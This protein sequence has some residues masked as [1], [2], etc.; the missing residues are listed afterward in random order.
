ML[1]MLEKLIPLATVFIFMGTITSADECNEISA[2]NTLYQSV[3][4]STASINS[5][6]RLQQTIGVKADG[7][8]GRRSEV[9]YEQLISKCNSYSYLGSKAIVESG[10]VADFFQN[11]TTFERVPY[12]HCS[13]KKQPIYG[14]IQSKPNADAAVGGAIIGGIIGKIVTEK[15]QGALIGALIGSAIASENQM[16]KTS[17]GIIGHENQLVCKT[18]YKNVPKNEIVYSYSTLTFILEGKEY[19]VDFNKE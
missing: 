16:A 11:K 18:A 15:D 5:T 7:V 1:M 9:A 12:E 17:T 4:T 19:V 3:I 6:K 14:Q 2:I 8:W 10:E 13:N